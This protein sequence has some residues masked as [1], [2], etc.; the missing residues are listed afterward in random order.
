LLSV[1]AFLSADGGAISAGAG[2]GTGA[3]G[4][5]TFNHNPYLMLIAIYLIT[6]ILTEM[7]TNNAAAVLVF[8]IAI[9]TAGQLD[10]SALPFIMTVLFA[11]SASFATPIGYQTN[12]MV[13]GPGGYRYS[14]FLKVGLPL[15]LIVAGLT[16]W[17]IPQFFPF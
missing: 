1:A 11:A 10:V 4:V 16:L 7:M 15:N 9:A 14:D 3:E 5:A 6:W 17:L 13:M 2:A 12:L 8:P